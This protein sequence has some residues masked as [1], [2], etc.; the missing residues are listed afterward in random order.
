VLL[1]VFPKT[2][3]R[4]TR[5]IQRARKALDRCIAEDHDTED[6]DD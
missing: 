5:Q 4:E 6:E 2:R 1:T 3:M